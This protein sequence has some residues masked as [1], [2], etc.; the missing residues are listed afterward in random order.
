M[1]RCKMCNKDTK[2]KIYCSN[3]C[4]FSDDE[5]NTRRCKKSIQNDKLKLLQCNK[6]KWTSKD[7]NNMSGTI[8]RH[9]KNCYNINKTDFNL[10]TIIDIPIIEKFNCPLC[11]WDTSDLN[12][13]SGWFTKHL[14]EIHTLSVDDFCMQFPKLK[15]LWIQY[16]KNKEYDIFISSDL[17][18]RIECKI[19][20]KT[21]KK[22]SNSHLQTHGITP[23]IYK[24][25]YNIIST[26]SNTTSKK[27]SYYSK[28]HNNIMKAFYMENDLPM[29]W[30][31]ESVYLSKVKGNF[32]KYIQKYENLFNLH[33]DYQQ[34]WRGDEFEVTC[35]TCLTRFISH[36]RS[37][38]CYTCNPKMK[39]FSKEEAELKKY[40]VDELKLDIIENDR[41]T[42]NKK[43]IDFLIP[44][45]NIGIEY[46]G[47]YWHSESE[48][49]FK[50][51][52]LNKTLLANKKGISLIHIFS[53]EWLNKPDIVK[54]RLMNIFNRIDN[55]IYARKC[56]IIEIDSK[57]K[58]IFL[59]RYH[60]Q[61]KDKS[62]IKLGAYYNNELVAVMTFGK[63]RRALGFKNNNS[64]E[65]ELI[66]FCSNYNYSVIGIAGKLLKYFVKN[67]NPISIISYADRRWTLNS[68]DNLYTKLGFKL[69]STSSP[70][71]WYLNDYLYRLHRFNFRKNILIENGADPNKT[72]WEIMQEK[73]YTR[74][75]DCGQF[76]YELILVD[77]N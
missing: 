28:Q 72:E 52:H 20:N 48:G 26:A 7:I 34:Y 70:G 1:N 51:Y 66:R 46:N 55:K 17:N 53:D 24:Q 6:C 54:G 2:C 15:K 35:K 4:K 12:N 45:F 19:C 69:E 76:K 14:K 42:L 22:L 65:Y 11:N 23:T 57:S 49:K 30:H 74:V 73:G 40:L 44:E 16:F 29:P 71:Y 47:L 77:S 5:Y 63:K 75:W 59:N 64:D 38:R 41:K 21:F 33:F 3:K 37:L 10:F 56:T 67:Y 32:K 18:N 36:N 60:I 9:C 43:E 31:I 25:K 62:S 13:K 61:G 58:D 8:K 39:G 50:D 68:A 27:Q